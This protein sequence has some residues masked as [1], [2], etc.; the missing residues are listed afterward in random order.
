MWGGENSHL[1]LFFWVFFR[2]HQYHIIVAIC[3][4]LLCSCIRCCRV[5]PDA[6][7]FI[8]TSLERFLHQQDM[9]TISVYT[10][11]LRVSIHNNCPTYS[12]HRFCISWACVLPRPCK[13]SSLLLSLPLPP[14]LPL[15]TMLP[16]TLLPLKLLPL[17]RPSLPWKEKEEKEEEVMVVMVVEEEEEEKQRVPA[18]DTHVTAPPPSARAHSNRP[19]VHA[20]ARAR[21]RVWRSVSPPGM[22]C[23]SLNYLP[24]NWSVSVTSAFTRCFWT[25]IKWKTNEI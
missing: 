19:S 12:I 17:K 5:F 9:R 21:A 24:V 25:A 1:C 7:V 16:T 10:S 15:P 18:Q 11:M 3:A 20:C 2:D 23:W 8:Y 13:R 22:L 6:V 4:C 14:L